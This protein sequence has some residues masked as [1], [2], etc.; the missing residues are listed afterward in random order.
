MIEE[1][2]ILLIEYFHF[3]GWE[4][5]E[6]FGSDYYFSF[7]CYPEKRF[8]FVLNKLFLVEFLT[9]KLVGHFILQIELANNFLELLFRDYFSEGLFLFLAESKKLQG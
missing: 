7:L 4:K 3:E 8:Y 9:E 5:T 2:Y 6:R 1:D